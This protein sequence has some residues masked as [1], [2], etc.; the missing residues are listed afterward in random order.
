MDIDQHEQDPLRHI[1]GGAYNGQ[2]GVNSRVEN[3]ERANNVGE[4]ED[5]IRTMRDYMNPIRKTPTSAIVFSTHHTTLNLKTKMLQ[6]LPQF[7]GCESESPYTHLKDFEDACSIFQDN[8]CPRKSY[9]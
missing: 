9:F 5:Q 4:V 7:H 8:S 1:L 3:H 6:A 2:H